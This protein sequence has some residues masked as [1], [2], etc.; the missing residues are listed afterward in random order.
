MQEMYFSLAT[1]TSEQLGYGF[2]RTG[3]HLDFV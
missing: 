1:D 2:V 3:V